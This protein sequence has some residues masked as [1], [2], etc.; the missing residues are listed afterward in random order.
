MSRKE[1]L[2]QALLNRPAKFKWKDLVVVMKDLGFIMKNAKRG[3]GRNFYNPT[4]GQVAKW[5]EPHPG[6]EVLQYVVDEA[7][8]LIKE[9]KDEK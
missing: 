5:H 7:I 6:N 3:S 4:T 9:Q 8:V 1:K 2:K